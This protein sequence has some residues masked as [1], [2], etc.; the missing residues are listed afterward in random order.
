MTLWL[1]TIRR[2]GS[3]G[4][5]LGVGVANSRAL[6]FYRAYGWIEPVLERPPPRTAVW[7]AM[8]L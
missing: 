1:D 4:A 3:R 7:M 8:P 2:L 6:R 5:H